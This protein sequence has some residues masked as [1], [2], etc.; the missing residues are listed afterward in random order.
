[1]A[2]IISPNCGAKRDTS[3]RYTSPEDQER[4][5]REWSEGH[6]SG[7]CQA[8]PSEANTEL[9]ASRPP[10]PEPWIEHGPVSPARVEV[11]FTDGRFR[12]PGDNIWMQAAC[13]VRTVEVR[14]L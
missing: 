13:R 1:M 12:G 10:M 8:K 5:N 6:R 7:K 2:W 4:D 9:Y 3:A 11:S 14:E